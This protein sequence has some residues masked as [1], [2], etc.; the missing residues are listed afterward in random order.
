MPVAH[1]PVFCGDR[2]LGD[3]RRLLAVL[4]QAYVAIDTAGQ[5]RAWNPA[6]RAT[7]G[8]SFEQVCG[9]DLAK[10]IIP[11][12][13]RRRHRDA[14][15]RLAAGG[16]GR[17][18]GQRLQLCAVHRDGHEFPIEMTLAVT[19]EGAGLVFHA[20]VQDVTTAQRVSRFTDVEAAVSRG[21][22]EAGS[23]AA[24]AVGVV[25]AVGERMGWPVVELWEADEHRQL[26]SCV[27]R[28]QAPELSLGP[29]AVD[30]LESGVGL[31]GRVYQ[32]GQPVW[33]TDL[34]A[35]TTSFRSRAAAR[36]GLH[37][38]VGVP[39]STGG[40]ILGA[41]CVYGDRTEDPEDTLTALLTGIAARIGQYLE[42]RRAEELTVELARTKD[43]FLAMVTHEL[44][45]PL[46]VITGASSVLEED[47]ATFSAD[48]QR[49]QLRTI[50]RSA[51]RLSVMAEDLL[52]LARLESGHLV[53][54]PV[55]TD[56]CMIIRE[57]V[58]AA[59]AA[60]DDKK[61]VLLVHVPPRLDMR[62]DPGRLRQVA[63]NLLSN[64]IKYTPAG[65]TITVT[66]EATDRDGIVW[67]VADTGIGIPA[68]D[69]PHLFRRFY[70]ASTAVQRRIPGTGLGL[71]ITRTIIERHDGSIG[72]AEPEVTGTT[73]VIRLPRMPPQP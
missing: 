15:A 27:A 42:R 16:S 52:D 37:V 18:L 3:P 65:G 11:V 73:F 70:R 38:A 22:L 67:T 61:Q 64:A 68:A 7:F 19:D 8:F 35:D 32:R 43:E 58:D 34:A 2:V 72:L 31:P 25:Q 33:I 40:T 1:D 46:A 44:R 14:L 62:A 49:A 63:D 23:S 39:V 9:E 26:L 59:T 30:E 54:R 4:S 20:F 56:L 53:L 69:R 10:L 45:N 41:L 50:T 5:V 29:F 57:A 36:I 66:A 47:L 28:H 17:L 6:A 21:L 48:E 13:F 12:R 60:A 55:D 51:Q 71:V 24:A